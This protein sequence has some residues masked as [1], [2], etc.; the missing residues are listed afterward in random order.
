MIRAALHSSHRPPGDQ[1]RDSSSSLSKS[2]GG[3]W[4]GLLGTVGIPAP[5]LTTIPRTWKSPIPLPLRR[6][7][8]DH[9]KPTGTIM[10]THL[11]PQDLYSKLLPK[12]LP[13][14]R[15]LAVPKNRLHLTQFFQMTS[16]EPF[17]RWGWLPLGFHSQWSSMMR[18]WPLLTRTSFPCITRF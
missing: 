18:V 7:G 11:S 6:R 12:V 5:C 8:S 15:Y 9:R 14:L 17:L 2:K 4:T 10:Q 13:S 3:D 1:G 16:S